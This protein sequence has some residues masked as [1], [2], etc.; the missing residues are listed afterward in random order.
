[1]S[2]VGQS[3]ALIDGSVSR[4]STLLFSLSRHAQRFEVEQTHRSRSGSAH[5]DVQEGCDK[6]GLSKTYRKVDAV[7]CKNPEQARSLL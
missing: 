7:S 1:M 5:Q 4:L 6:Y 2:S 3:H